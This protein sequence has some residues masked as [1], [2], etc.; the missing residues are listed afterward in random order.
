MRRLL[1]GLAAL[2]LVCLPPAVHAKPLPKHEG[3]YFW[4]VQYCGEFA[5]V[6]WV[7]EDKMYLL[8]SEQIKNQATMEM[9]MAA[10]ERAEKLGQAYVIDVAGQAECPEV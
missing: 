4:A 7:T 10:R 3:T 9:I 8:R 2:F 1:L 5:G 6:F